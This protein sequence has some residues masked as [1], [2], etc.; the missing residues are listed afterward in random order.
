M[1]R[2]SVG[3]KIAT[4]GTPSAAARCIAPESF[5]TNASQRAS[6]PASSR[7]SVRP[8][9]LITRMPAGSDDS[10]SR[11]A[12]RSPA[13]PTSTQTAWR[14]LGQPAD[15]LSDAIRR[16]PFRVA[17]GG[18]W[19]ET[20]DHLVPGDAAGGEQLVGTAARGGTHDHAR[21]GLRHRQTEGTHEL[22]V[23]FGLVQA[24]LR[25]RH[26][27]CKE[28]APDAAPRIPQRSRIP[29]RRAVHADA[30][31]VGKK[32]RGV[33][34]AGPRASRFSL[35]PGAIDDD[36]RPA[37]PGV[38]SSKSGAIDEAPRSRRAMPG[39]AART[40]AIAGSAMT[41]SPSQFGART[42]RREGA[43][44]SLIPA[45]SVVRCG[46][47]PLTFSASGMSRHRRCIH[48]HSSG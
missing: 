6:T 47:I 1:T 5:D 19:R 33:E 24:L 36:R 40:A 13:A 16:P 4:T 27:A 28:R 34:T 9:R 23:V 46:N 32:E 17:V 44:W 18:A 45:P 3:P 21:Q 39:K 20:D 14:S 11:P 12:S 2:S 30:K 26:P 22:G 38:S 31:G 35:S 48:S 8:I 7:R 29:A 41:A 37:R 42:T 25:P 10:I 43:A 15:D